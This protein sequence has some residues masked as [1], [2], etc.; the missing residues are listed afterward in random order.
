MIPLVLAV[1]AQ[2][3]STSFDDLSNWLPGSTSP[4]VGWANDGTPSAV[5]GGAART[6]ANSLNYNNGA[7]YDSPGISNEGPVFSPVIPLTGLAAPTL[8]FWCNFHTQPG[9]ED[10][11]A[12]RDSRRITIAPGSSPLITETLGVTN[13]G[14]RVGPC[15]A[16]GTWHRH[17]MTLEPA[18]G[19]IQLLFVFST[20]DALGNGYGGWF[21]DDLA[22]SEPPPPVTPGPAP[23]PAPGPSPTPAPAPAPAA[24]SD[25][26]NDNGDK[27]GCGTVNSVSPFAALP[28]L[29]LLLGLAAR[30]RV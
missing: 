24:V 18:W 21:I 11:A 9:S 27:C 20:G 25:R 4:P 12:A 14:T 5:P 23:G 1:F 16:M 29:L 30:K 19:Q 2:G 13:A 17:T 6:G 26:D 10:A 3:Y 7:N 22:V 28:A 15:S 8:S